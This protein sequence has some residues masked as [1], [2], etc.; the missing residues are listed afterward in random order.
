MVKAFDPQ[1]EWTEPIGYPGAGTHH[2]P[3]VTAH[4]SQ[5][6]STWAEGSCEP[7]RLIVAGDK[8]VVFVH[9]RVRLKQETE[10]REARLADVYTF[11]N[12]KAI[13]VRS[14]PDRRQALEWAGAKDLEAG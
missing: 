14:F 13:Q 10:F 7:E 8:I 9:V 6:R 1:V 12:G 11:R 4:L 5:A 2:G 3:G